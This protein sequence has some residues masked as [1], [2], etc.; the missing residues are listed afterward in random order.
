MT[1]PG[2]EQTKMKK[3]PILTGITLVCLLPALAF[4]SVPVSLDGLNFCKIFEGH[5]ESIEGNITI[6]D[7][8]TGEIYFNGPLPEDH[9][10][11]IQVLHGT[12]LLIQ[13]KDW[14]GQMQ[15][16]HIVECKWNFDEL[17]N[18]IPFPKSG[19]TI[20]SG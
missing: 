10:I 13:W 1:R 17:I 14:R 15:E 16:S 20:G 11:C 6:T 18:C 8:T 2:G 19:E 4:A 7:A 3:L 12:E 5:V 9:K